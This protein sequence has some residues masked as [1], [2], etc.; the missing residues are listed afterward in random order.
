MTSE[1][2]IVIQMGAHCP[3]DVFTSA[4][5]GYRHCV[6][7]GA[8]LQAEESVLIEHLERCHTGAMLELMKQAT[9]N[10]KSTCKAP[11]SK[12]R[13]ITI[14]PS[15]VISRCM[16]KL[17]TTDET[18]AALS[19][20]LINAQIPVNVVDDTGF[21][22]C[23]HLIN[24]RYILPSSKFL[25][26]AS[27]LTSQTWIVRANKSVALARKKVRDL[28][29]GEARI[30]INY[31]SIASQ[32]VPVLNRSSRDIDVGFGNQIVGTVEALSAGESQVV[33]NQWKGQRVLVHPIVTCGLCTVCVSKSGD[34]PNAYRVGRGD[35]SMY[36][37]TERCIFPLRALHPIPKSVSS[38]AALLAYPLSIALGLM[39]ELEDTMSLNETYDT[40]GLIGESLI[41]M[42][43]YRL[44]ETYHPEYNKVILRWGSERSKL[45]HSFKIKKIKEI[46]LG[47]SLDRISFSVCVECTQTVE[48][49]GVA[50]QC[51][52]PM[53]VVVVQYIDDDVTQYK[54]DASKLISPDPN[55][56]VVNELT[57]KT[58]RPVE[59]ESALNF[60]KRFQLDK[61]L[62]PRLPTNLL[63]PNVIFTKRIG[64]GE[65]GTTVSVNL[66]HDFFTVLIQCDVAA[67]ADNGEEDEEDDETNSVDEIESKTS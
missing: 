17:N 11:E 12:K 39:Y 20:W 13:S 49:C 61:P 41:S 38:E 27:G 4:I 16:L 14:T 15:S 48:G 53:G 60:I 33:V 9:T 66:V 25:T 34:C 40:I 8:E 64:L 3:E 30:K 35:S 36:G 57:I 21:R 52:N 22:K 65:I 32:D 63:D 10:Q 54:K 5:S 19:D 45:L 2:E 26:N 62:S 29:S 46:H 7:C 44:L 6:L 47:Q 51:T 50:F 42:L 24:P 67:V 31:A 55:L 59:F 1:A 28:R 43:L 58:V 18:T 37:F 56:I 23:L